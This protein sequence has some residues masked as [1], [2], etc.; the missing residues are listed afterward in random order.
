VHHLRARVED[1]PVTVCIAAKYDGGTVCVSD[2]AISYG[3]NRFHTPTIKGAHRWDGFIMYAGEPWLCHEVVWD[4]SPCL[5]NDVIKLLAA[6]YKDDDTSHPEFPA[7]FLA[8]TAESI[9][10]MGQGEI[11]GD[12]D[13]ACIGSG[14]TT[15][16]PLLDALYKRV[17]NRT[18]S[19]TKKMLGE[20]MRL[21]EKYDPTVYRPFLFEVLV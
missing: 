2:T 14:S 4:T 9:Y 8:T 11:F 13:Y 12:Y 15:A 18:K 17:R 5:T 7:E 10:I 20:V 21:T 16:W 19:N 1:E 6:K 3:E